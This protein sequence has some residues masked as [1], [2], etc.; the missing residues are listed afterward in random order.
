MKK[1][2]SGLLSATTGPKNP[3]PLQTAVPPRELLL[4]VSQPG[5]SLFYCRPESTPPLR[6]RARVGAQEEGCDIAP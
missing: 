4:C 3:G 5:L 6:G 2:A 1:P